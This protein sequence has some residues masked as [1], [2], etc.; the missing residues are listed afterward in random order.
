MRKAA[1]VGAFGSDPKLWK[2]LRAAVRPAARPV[3]R[4]QRLVH[5]PPDGAGAPSA[6]RAAAETAI[7]FAAGSGGGLAGKRRTDV[8]V[9]Q[10]VAGTDD[11][12]SKGP[13]GIG[14]MRN[15]AI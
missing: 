6:L 12:R 15:Y 8:V 7:D 10:H 2:K 11:H 14:R 3:G 5:D 9:G 13:G 1:V 4:R